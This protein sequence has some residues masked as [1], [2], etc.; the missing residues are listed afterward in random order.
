MGRNNLNWQRFIFEHLNNN[1]NDVKAKE[2]LGDI[3]GHAKDWDTA[4]G[5]IGWLK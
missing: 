5:I 3:A 1:P 2:F 4:M